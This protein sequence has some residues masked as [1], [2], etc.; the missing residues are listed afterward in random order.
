MKEKW[1]QMGKGQR[2]QTFAYLWLLLGMLSMMVVSSFA[3]FSISPTPRVNDM[4]LYVNAPVGL[5][6]ATEYSAPDELWGQSINFTELV[7]EG[8]PLKPVTWS[9][10]DQCFKAIRYGRD[11]RQS[12][13]LKALSD[14]ENANRIGDDQYY[15]K[16]VFYARTD[17]KCMISLA[18]AVEL[19][20]GQHGAGTYVIGTPVWNARLEAHEDAGDGAQYAVRIGFLVS[21][22]D[23][24][25]G[26]TAGETEFFVYEPNADRHLSGSTQVMDTRSCD[27]TET[28]V[29]RERL[30][31]QS[32]STWAEADPVERDSTV[33]TLGTFLTD[34]ELFELDEGEVVQIVMYIWV[35][36]QDVDCYGLPEDASLFANVQFKANYDTQS[37]MEEIPQ[38]E[39]E[40]EE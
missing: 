10:Q 28:L 31:V 2:L 13:R 37:G 21:K 1:M 6:I 3:W 35:E 9:E 29:S 39:P 11:G 12:N 22:I 19:S 30:I 8:S 20:N 27:G 36:G 15:T 38:D 32:T 40:P 33:K 25:T 16:G 24:D 14:E 34:A 26:E 7:S 4:V 5:Q 23:P 18:E 17:A